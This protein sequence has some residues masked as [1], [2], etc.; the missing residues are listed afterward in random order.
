[1][2]A[3]N[4]PVIKGLFNIFTAGVFHSEPERPFCSGEIL[5]LDSTQVG[6]CITGMVKRGMA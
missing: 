4:F 5:C 2:S 3:E 1:M 6:N